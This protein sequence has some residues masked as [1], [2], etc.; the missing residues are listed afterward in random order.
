MTDRSS[1]IHFVR[2]DTPKGEGRVAVFEGLGFGEFQLGLKRLRKH[3]TNRMGQ[4]FDVSVEQLAAIELSLDNVIVEDS[5]GAVDDFLV[6][7]DLRYDFLL[8]VTRRQRD[9]KVRERLPT[10]SRKL[11]AFELPQDG[12]IE[13]TTAKDVRV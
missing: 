13:A 10:Y 3:I 8:H 11:C 2:F 6:S 5:A 4:G 1:Q 12:I 7:L 9:F